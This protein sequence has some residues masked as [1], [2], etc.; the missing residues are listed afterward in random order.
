MAGNKPL[1]ITPGQNDEIVAIQYK[2]VS[3]KVYEVGSQPI[4]KRNQWKITANGG[5]EYVLEVGIKSAL[6]RDD[7]EDLLEDFDHVALDGDELFV[8]A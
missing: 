5:K 7:Q 6:Q 1:P 3:F 8:I 2:K 4:T